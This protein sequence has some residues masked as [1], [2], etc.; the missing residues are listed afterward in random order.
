MDLTNILAISGKPD[1]NEMVSRTKNGAIVKNLVNGQ[2]FPVFSSNS[3]SQLSEIRMFTTEDEKPLEEIFQNAYNILEGKPTDFDPK[4]ADSKEL[5][6]LL[7]KVLPN[8]DAD[9]VHT[10]DAKKLFSWYNIL[11]AAGKLTAEEEEEKAE[12][13]ADAPATKKP[14]TPKKPV[15]PKQAAPKATTQ[16]K[17]APKRTTTAKK[18]I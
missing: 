1:L 2:K 13:T 15:A 8:Y 14:A 6:D 16:A 17:A 12:E 10:S 7:A 5:F 9:R 4:K 11:L 18:A 3:I